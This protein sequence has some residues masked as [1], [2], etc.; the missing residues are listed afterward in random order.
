MLSSHT[1][2]YRIKTSLSPTAKSIPRLPM[3]DKRCYVRDNLHM[4]FDVPKYRITL[5][6]YVYDVGLCN[7]NSKFQTSLAPLFVDKNSKWWKCVFLEQKEH[8]AIKIVRLCG[9]VL[10][11][12][13]ISDRSMF[14]QREL[15]IHKT[16]W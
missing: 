2:P 5:V 14:Q 8:F 12:S 15:V 7:S 1:H 13:F 10:F 11:R 4:T 9:Y 16:I 6:F 3:W